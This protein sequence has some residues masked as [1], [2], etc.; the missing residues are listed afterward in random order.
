MQLDLFE[1]L[2]AGPSTAAGLAPHLN[3]T[4]EAT[5]RLL[6]A[7]AALGLTERRGDAYG[8]GPLGAAMVDN[9][10]VIAMVR[11]HAAVYRDLAD[12]VAL[13]RGG[14]GD[15]A[16]YWPYAGAAQP[17]ALD[18]SQVAAYSELMAASQPL[19][20]AEILDAYDVGRHKVLMDVAG[21]D[22]RF[23]TAAA[24]RAP[25]LQLVL[26]DLPAVAARAESRFADAGLT[27]RARAVGGDAFQDALPTGADL[28][29]LVRVVHDH[30]DE[31]AMA[32]LRA[33]HKALPRGG[34][35][36]LGEPMAGMRG[37]E[38]VGDAYFGMYL[39]AMGSGRARTQTQLCRMLR[40]AG[41]AAAR[42]RRTATPL[43]T[44][45]IVAFA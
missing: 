12:P 7:A 10:A 6:A 16:A 35:L 43:Q 18:A 2:A 29:S 30:D 11:H 34:T 24:A 27:A 13:L 1:R 33:V 38:T 32:L 19:V 23:L 14:R 36:L 26:F 4:T 41:F 28:I 21:G 44:G 5:D 3:L 45:L 37:A 15:L 9:P 31:A 22:G 20:A 42:P 25:G 39:L 8:L 17:G 40:E